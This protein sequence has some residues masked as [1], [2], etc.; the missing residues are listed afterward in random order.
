MP[1]PKKRVG[2]SD[3]AHRRANWKAT[4]SPQTNCPHCGALNMP[5]CLCAECGFYKDRIVSL[6]MHAHHEH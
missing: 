5:H 2:K 3:Q 4:L 1:V 6:K